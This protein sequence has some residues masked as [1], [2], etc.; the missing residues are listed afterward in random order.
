M[1]SI[2]TGLG[3]DYVLGSWPE[4]TLAALQ[5]RQELLFPVNKSAHFSWLLRFP[6]SLPSLIHR[7]FVLRHHLLVCNS[8]RD[9]YLFYR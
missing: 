3:L 1:G 9:K 6:L 5:F 2:V 8:P 4:F 7:S